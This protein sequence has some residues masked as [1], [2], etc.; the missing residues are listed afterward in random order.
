[1]TT[2]ITTRT[3][4]TKLIQVPSHLVFSQIFNNQFP[5]LKR[6]QIGNKG[7][8]RKM[9]EIFKNNNPPPFTVFFLEAFFAFNPSSPLK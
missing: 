6:R 5:I 9:P 1:M 2:N 3:N 4:T 7:K 8:P